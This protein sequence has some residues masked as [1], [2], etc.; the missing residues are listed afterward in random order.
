MTDAD[1][2]RAPLSA[3]ECQRR[4]RQRK[5]VT[6]RH[7]TSPGDTRNAL[8]VVRVAGQDRDHVRRR[9]RRRHHADVLAR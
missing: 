7:E 4:Y 5:G 9:R 2:D 1:T 8:T 6:E 3:A